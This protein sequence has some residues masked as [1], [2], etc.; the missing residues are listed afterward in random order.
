M[1]CSDCK[2]E[3][4]ESWETYDAWGYNYRCEL[5]LD[6]EDADEK[7]SCPKFKDWKKDLEMTREM[8]KPEWHSKWAHKDKPKERKL[9][10]WIKPFVDSVN[11][12]FK[13]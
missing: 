4:G 7:Q 12:R 5:G 9:D 2:Y 13:Q 8:N 6:C 10:D 11:E 1:F 3:D